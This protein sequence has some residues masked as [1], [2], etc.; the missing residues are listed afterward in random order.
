MTDR[1]SRGQQQRRRLSSLVREYV[2]RVAAGEELTAAS[3]AAEHP[4][5]GEAL[6]AR[7]RNLD[8]PSGKREGTRSSRLE[9][10]PPEIPG[11]EVIAELGLGGMGVVFKAYHGSSRRF[12]A[13]KVMQPRRASSDV[14]RRR[15]EREVEIPM[16]LDYPSIVRVY[17]AGLTGGLPFYTMDY[18]DGVPLDR[19]VETRGSSPE[20]ILELFVKIC[21]AVGHAHSRSVVH[22]DLKPGN[23]LV[24]EAGEPHLMD[25][26]LAK[27]R[28]S[29]ATGAGW[30]ED[31]T[32]AGQMLGTLPYLSP[33][34]AVGDPDELDARTDV[35]SLGVMLYR[36]LTGV[37]PVDTSGPLPEALLRI[38]DS[39]P[40]PPST[41][42]TAIDGRLQDV[43]LKALEKDR[44]RR[45]ASVA[46]LAAELSEC[47]AALSS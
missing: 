45:H 27:V 29:D 17:D 21:E 39:P 4:D 33:E 40:I 22:R 36:L 34:Q 25:F 20:A 14:A 10:T 30:P 16:L 44:D 9:E 2:G 8:P 1:P 43:L 38:L 47:L 41:L 11:Y 5:V 46:E 12:V 37:L 28:C 32:R 26:G 31:V 42:S 23:V 13:L 15:F 7:L 24:D 35:Y 18:V 6:Q 3:F 19:W